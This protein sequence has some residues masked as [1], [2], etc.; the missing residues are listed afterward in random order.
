MTSSEVAWRETGSVTTDDTSGR[1]AGN[2]YTIAGLKNNT[3]YTITVT[4]YNLA[5]RNISQPILVTTG[6]YTIAYMY[7]DFH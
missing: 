3:E 7:K 1:I 6:K 2:A 5:G 4:V